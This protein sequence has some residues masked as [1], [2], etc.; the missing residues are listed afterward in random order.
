MDVM[1]KC[2]GV[3]MSLLLAGCQSASSLQDGQL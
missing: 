3:V 2:L 1:V